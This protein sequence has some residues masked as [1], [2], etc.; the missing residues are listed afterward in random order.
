MR[1]IKTGLIEYDR[2]R[3][4]NGYT[5]FSPINAHTTY[6]IDME[7]EV[8]H[9]WELPLPPGNYAYLLANGNLLVAES[10][11]IREIDPQGKTVWRHSGKTASGVSRY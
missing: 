6:L 10:N 8:V 2:S 5:L 4:T 3:A 1:C 7:G 9:E 11:G